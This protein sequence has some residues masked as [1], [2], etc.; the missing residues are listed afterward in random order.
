MSSDL[1][2]IDAAY[3]LLRELHDRTS[4][5]PRQLRYGLGVEMLRRADAILGE[6]IACKFARHRERKF[7]G[8]TWVNVELE[9]LRFQL[10]LSYDVR[11]LNADAHRHVLELV[12]NVGRQVGGWRKSVGPKDES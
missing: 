7:D 4:R 10:R 5:F 6:L 12:A 8:L 3:E 1:A 9:R 11:A 2:I